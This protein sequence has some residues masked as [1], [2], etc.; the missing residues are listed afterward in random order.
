MWK[1]N[2][3]PL[4]M[5]MAVIL[6]S[7]CGIYLTDNAK[8]ASLDTAQKRNT[9]II[10]P[11]DNDHSYYQTFFLNKPYFSGVEISFSTTGYRSNNDYHI[12]IQIT[13]CNRVEIFSN[14]YSIPRSPQVY[15]LNLSFTPQTR[16]QNQ[17]YCLKL[18]TNS[19]PYIIS[20]LG[21]EYDTYPDGE[22]LMSEGYPTHQDLSF[23][24]YTKPPFYLYTNE[25]IQKSW[26][27]ILSLFLISLIIYFLGYTITFIFLKNCNSI[28]FVIYTLTTGIS[29]PA[30]LF[31]MLGVFNFNLDIG[32]AILVSLGIISMAIMIS[33]IVFSWKIN[34]S[35][36]DV[37]K[38]E[39]VALIVILSFATATR[40][41]QISDLFV[42]SG[43]GE[44]FHEK[45]IEGMVLKRVLRLD[46]IYHTGFHSNV[47]TL[48]ELLNISIPEAT[49]IY[50]Q[51]LS[52]VSGLTF[53]LLS[54]KIFKN[55]LYALASTAIYYFISPLPAYL[56]N[57][58]RYPYLQGLTILPCCIHLF[59][60]MANGSFSNKVIAAIVSIG[61]LLSHY[62]TMIIL[63]LLMASYV[64][65]KSLTLNFRLINTKEI[66]KT[67]AILLPLVL[68]ATIKLY[69]ITTH[70][71]WLSF[72]G[73][74]EI[75]YT[76][77]DYLY[78]FGHTLTHGGTILWLLG[79]A[80]GIVLL[81]QRIKLLRA[82]IFFIFIYSLIDWAQT[83]FFGHSASSLINMMFFLSIPMAILAGYCTKYF[84]NSS[85]AISYLF[86]ATI[87]LA[88][89]Y[90][91]SGIVNPRNVFYSSADQEAMSWIK[92]NLAINDGFL[93][94]S[95]P[96]EGKFEP[97]DGGYWITYF[98]G[99]KTTITN[100]TNDYE[101]LDKFIQ[102]SNADY[103]YIG[104]G[105]GSITPT[106]MDRMGKTLLYDKDGIYIYD[107]R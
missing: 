48:T 98:T 24:T 18:H 12:S 58:G 84:L 80:G 76:F 46:A 54:R 52:I 51:W 96:W 66:L 50:G 33:N 9:S 14:E 92:N 94:N 49:L 4:G 5:V 70:G 43:I 103:V 56:I 81:T 39:I 85:K 101:E 100:F 86:L 29:I 83:F 30:I 7:C 106:I 31:F 3:T 68:A 79:I 17:T 73:N 10:G 77:E 67:G 19:P 13:D 8:F 37:P 95:Y 36:N 102:K 6:I 60:G 44:Q 27:R 91:I 20:P 87:I 1:S 59:W 63:V 61:L 88:G 25:L 97:S 55:P 62:G 93:I 99:H 22:L 74:K 53:Y 107:L 47:F 23:F 32:I 16:S 15:D 78:S 38:W 2:I 72:L 21:S 69:R 57:V 82:T 40:L 42:P 65:N 35:R 11:F 34:K 104:S 89:S 28:E 64:F 90:N 105:F 75:S 41:S 71:A 26:M 45:I